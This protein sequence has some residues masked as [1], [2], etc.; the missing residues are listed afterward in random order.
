MLAP[1]GFSK[2]NYACESIVHCIWDGD[3]CG[4]L[5]Y[6]NPLGDLKYYLHVTPTCSIGVKKETI[7]L[8]TILSN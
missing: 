6:R 2:V 8:P 4:L 1:S 5:S 3:L 7:L